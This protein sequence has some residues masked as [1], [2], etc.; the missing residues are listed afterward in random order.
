MS[1][2]LHFHAVGRDRRERTSSAQM[3]VDVRALH[4]SEKSFY[5]QGRIRFLI[6]PTLTF[7][8]QVRAATAASIADSMRFAALFLRTGRSDASLKRLAASDTHCLGSRASRT[9]S[10]DLSSALGGSKA[11]AAVRSSSIPTAKTWYVAAP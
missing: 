10:V 6:V 5:G 11:S 7:R 9:G 8:V 3:C 4:A 1:S 2:L